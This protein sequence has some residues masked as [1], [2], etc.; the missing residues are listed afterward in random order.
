[1][2]VFWGSISTRLSAY[3]SDVG[4]RDGRSGGGVTELGRSRSYR[5]RRSAQFPV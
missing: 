4:L 3:L 1:M 2:G 5:L